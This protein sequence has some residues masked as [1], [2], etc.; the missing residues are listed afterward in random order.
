MSNGNHAVSR[1]ELSLLPLRVAGIALPWGVSNWVIITCDWI[2]GK[3]RLEY[4]SRGRI[5]LT[6][7]AHCTAWLWEKASWSVTGSDLVDGPRKAKELNPRGEWRKYSEIYATDI[8][9]A[10]GLNKWQSFYSDTTGYMRAAMLRVGS[11]FWD[12]HSKCRSQMQGRGLMHQYN[13]FKELPS[14][15]ERH[16]WRGIGEIDTYWLPWT[17]SQSD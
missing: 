2:Y 11:N 9:R 5:L 14:T 8:G 12:L 17:T 1:N 16:F 7:K 4:V 13:C 6:Y 3:W 10:T 15:S